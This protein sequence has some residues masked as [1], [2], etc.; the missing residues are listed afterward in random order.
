MDMITWFS[1]YLLCLDKR[2]LTDC[3]ELKKP[4]TLTNFR[5]WKQSRMSAKI[6]KEMTLLMNA[7]TWKNLKIGNIQKL[8]TKLYHF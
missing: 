4:N 1:L 5:T 8:R 2:Y 7:N 6:F 3:L